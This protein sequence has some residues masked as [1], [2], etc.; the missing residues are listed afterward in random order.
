[1]HTIAIGR[2][3]AMPR[4]RRKVNELNSSTIIIRCITSDNDILSHFRE[5]ITYNT[6]TAMFYPGILLYLTAPAV[7]I[8]MLYRSSICFLCFSPIPDRSIYL[9]GL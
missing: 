2:A 6:G 4:N 9:S 8:N 7:D 3:S 1:M 5:D